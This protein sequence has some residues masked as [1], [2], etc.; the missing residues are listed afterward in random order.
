LRALT[1]V[2]LGTWGETA[3]GARW[4]T[5]LEFSTTTCADFNSAQTA[6]CAYENTLFNGGYRYQGRVLGHST[7]S[8][9]RQWVL[10]LLLQ[11]TAARTWTARLRR[12]EV[13]RIGG[14]NQVNQLLSRTPQLWWVGEATLAQPFAGGHVEAALGLEHR[15]DESSGSTRLE[16]RGY[17]RFTHD[18]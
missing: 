17:L 18:F 7:D 9:S 5:H 14:P 10:G 12:A 4:R 15:H 13:N 11:D 2:S 6:D 1:L 16:P 3:G 8:D